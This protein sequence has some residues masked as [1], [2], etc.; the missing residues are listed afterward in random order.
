M[1][2]SNSHRNDNA[3]FL[4]NSMPWF[5]WIGIICI[6][7]LAV[8]QCDTYYHSLDMK[9]LSQFNGLWSMQVYCFKLSTST[10]QDNRWGR[11]NI[12]LNLIN[13]IP[14][15]L[16]IKTI[17]LMWMCVTRISGSKLDMTEKSSSSEPSSL[18]F[19]HRT[20]LAAK[21]QPECGYLP[22]SADLS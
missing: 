21:L 5:V 6:I 17:K 9:F 1:C 19:F 12:N 10:V 22:L 8:L 16:E 11:L 15:L 7:A 3:S 20:L 18:F 13:G 2:H 14:A 4:Y